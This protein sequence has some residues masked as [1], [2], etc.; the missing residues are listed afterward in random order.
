MTN[1]LRAISCVISIFGSLSVWLFLQSS[2][3]WKWSSIKK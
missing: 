2:S 3:L 1:H